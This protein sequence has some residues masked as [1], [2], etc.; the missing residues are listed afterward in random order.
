VIGHVGRDAVHHDAHFHD[1]A[2]EADFI[3]KDLGAIGGSKDGFT[4]VEA[5]F[6]AVDIERGHDLDVPRAV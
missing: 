1:R 5:D 6:A 4:D 2:G 3:A